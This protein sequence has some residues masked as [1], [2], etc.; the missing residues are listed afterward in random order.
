MMR[1]TRSSGPRAHGMCSPTPAI[2]GPHW[3][4]GKFRLLGFRAFLCLG[5]EGFGASGYDGFLGF[6]FGD[7]GC[8]VWGLELIGVQGHWFRGL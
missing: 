7:L 8:R 3:K 2:A 4:W 1:S 5:V 6:G